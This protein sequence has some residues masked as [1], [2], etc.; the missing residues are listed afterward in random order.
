M[1]DHPGRHGDQHAEQQPAEQHTEQHAQDRPAGDRAGGRPPARLPWGIRGTGSY[2]PDRRVASDELSRSLGLDPGWIEERTGIRHRHTAAPGQAASDLAALA[3]G[4]ALAAA[5]LDAADIGLI[6][7]G[8]STPDE[9]GPS[10]ACRTQALLGARHAAA[11]DVAAACS[12]FVYGLQTAAGWLATQHGAAPYALV[13]GV[14]VY[15]RFLDAGD[16]ATAA[17]FGDGAAAAVLGPVPAPYG[18]ASMTLGSD[19]TRADDVL[20]PA[21]GSRAPA[22]PAT[23]AGLGHTI[24]MDGR[25]VRKFISEIFPRLVADATAGAGLR[26][27]DLDLVVPHQP[28]P[29]LVASLAPAAGLD[30]A[31]LAIA[32]HDVG[33]IGA[34]SL[35]YALDQ[36]VRAGRAGPGDLVLLAGF[37]AGLTWGHTLLVWPPD[38]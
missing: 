22:T 30:T 13:I 35:P 37:G 23:L 38:L 1:S 17:L 14:E 8:T 20:I 36:A 26:P 27:A 11:F 9:L 5:G 2:L 21:G 6:V 12:G 19:G 34:A 10:T 18:I 15:S 3:A 25:A 32:G 31:R 33:N 16:R 4:R 29:R 24:H 28:N 7:L